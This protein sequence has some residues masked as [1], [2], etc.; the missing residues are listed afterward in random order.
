MQGHAASSQRIVIVGAGGQAANVFGVAHALGYE[1]HC[2]LHDGKAGQT[3]L[4]SPVVGCVEDIAD[5]EDLCFAVGVGDNA[6]R[7][8]YAEELRAKRPRLCFPPLIHPSASIGALSS[9]AEGALVMPNAVIGCGASLG[10]FS[11]VGAQAYVGHD[12]RL[13]DYAS[14]GPGAVIAGRVTIGAR[15]VVA[16]SASVREGLTIGRDSILGWPVGG[17]LW[18]GRRAHRPALT[19]SAV[20]P[21]I[22]R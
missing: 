17:V 19:C 18:P 14:A 22:W 7:E 20:R 13:G 6:S 15:S 9:I 1:V 10:Q 2:F 4:G 3:F 8:R 16:L 5:C 12:T 11:T 21:V